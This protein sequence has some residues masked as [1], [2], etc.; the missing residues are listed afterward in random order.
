VFTFAWQY[1]LAANIPTISAACVTWYAIDLVHSNLV[2]ARAR[3]KVW[4]TRQ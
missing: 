1:N 3:T 2:V 4:F